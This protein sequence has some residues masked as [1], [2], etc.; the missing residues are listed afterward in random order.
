MKVIVGSIVLLI[1]SAC[2][3]QNQGM[4]EK[5]MSAMRIS[6]IS[7]SSGE[8]AMAVEVQTPN[9]CWK[10]SRYTV[11]KRD[12]NYL[13][14]VYAQKDPEEICA[15]IIGSFVTN[16]KIENVDAGE[17]DIKVW[18]NEVEHIDTTVVVK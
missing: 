13:V 11:D 14:T 15:Q 7:S 4:E 3:A 12:G 2:A 18:C 5:P 1:L 10:F 16:V 17:C 6:E 8:V 9:P